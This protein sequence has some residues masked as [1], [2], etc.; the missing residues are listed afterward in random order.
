VSSGKDKS[1]TDSESGPMRLV[2]KVFPKTADFYALLRAQSGASVQSLALLGEFMES[3]GDPDFGARVKA[4]ERA[5]SAM[6]EESMAAL[7]SAFSTPMDREDLYRAISTLQRI[8]TYART[9]VREMEVLRVAPDEHTIRLAELLHDGAVALDQGYAVLEDDPAAGEALA[10]RARVC[11][12]RVEKQYRRALA[13]LF[14]P[15]EDVRRLEELD[16]H[17]G[18]AAYAMVMDVFKRREVY[19]HLSNAGD[20]IAR[21]GDT[22]HDIVVKLV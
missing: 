7:N 15:A 8:T 20:R 4:N 18:P 19:R 3:D 11:E 1:V 22:L 9:T 12:R 14:D 13:R 17:T 2:H 5:A 10:D 6:R 16:G 21:A